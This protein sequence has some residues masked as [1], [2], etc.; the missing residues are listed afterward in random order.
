M[1]SPSAI[2]EP[3]IEARIA[4]YAWPSLQADLDARGHALLP[5]LL[6]A[7]ECAELRATYR[8]PSRF[9]SRIVMARHNFGRGE[10]QYFGDPLPELVMQLRA[11]SYPRLAPI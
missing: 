9:R 6:S 3:S 7:R 1:T 4:S 2:H 8:D 10:Y 5:A 11:A